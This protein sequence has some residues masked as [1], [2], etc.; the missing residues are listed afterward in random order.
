MI[1][2]YRERSNT[3]IHFVPVIS[4]VCLTIFSFVVQPTK[5]NTKTNQLEIPKFS[6]EYNVIGAAYKPPSKEKINT[7]I[8]S[9]FSLPNGMLKAIHLKETSGNCR[10]K[11]WVGAEGCFQFMPKTRKYVENK[12][13]INIDPFEY[14]SAARGS[15]MYLEYLKNK[16]NKHYPDLR[17]NVKWSLTLA[18]YNA[19]PKNGLKW[20]KI[21]KSKNIRT[22]E[23]LTKYITFKETRRYVN[24][25][26]K[27]IFSVEYEV[28]K[29]DTL[30]AIS[31][32]Y[33]VPVEN[34]IATT[35]GEN[36]KIGQLITL[37]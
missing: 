12:F 37:Y 26:S 35:G 11:S 27:Q 2:C 23:S 24:I 34:L 17:E 13:N 4:I 18:S 10:A 6:Q 22:V 31:S 28:K 20:A 33:G 36:I 19:G 32:K 15:S 14:E 30:Y 1:E 29:G 21:A 9:E 3:L 7:W 16:I 5:E 25:I 8:E